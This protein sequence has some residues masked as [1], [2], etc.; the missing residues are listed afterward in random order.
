M[1]RSD[2]SAVSLPPGPHSPAQAADALLHAISC[3]VPPALLEEYGLA[4]APEQAQRIAR[5]VLSLNLFWLAQ[6][7]EA[8]MP[9]ETDQTRLWEALK[10]RIAA[11]WTSQWRLPAADVSAYWEEAEA[12]RAAYD[13][14]VREG[15]EPM[16]VFGETADI[17]EADWVVRGED[18][19]KLLAFLLDTVPVDEIGD[20]VEGLD[21]APG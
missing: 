17:L 14:I 5:E 11:A 20:A 21:L 9:A 3:D 6:A 4:G 10:P 2:P 16:S 19:Q 18:R 12:R 13:R 1:N 8:H 15:G 7:F